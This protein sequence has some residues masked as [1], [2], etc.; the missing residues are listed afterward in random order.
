[1]NCNVNVFDELSF[2]PSTIIVIC[3]I[4]SFIMFFLKRHEMQQ[5]SVHVVYKYW[6]CWIY[7]TSSAHAVQKY[8]LE[9]TFRHCCR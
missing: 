7:Q 1:M 5:S 2:I 6:R 9:I 4:H 8:I 3:R